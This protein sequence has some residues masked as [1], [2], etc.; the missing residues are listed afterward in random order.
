[1]YK[2][3]EEC[4]TIV[5][6]SYAK[7]DVGGQALITFKVDTAVTTQLSEKAKKYRQQ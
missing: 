7:V 2:R 3:E 1:M 5:D 6:S 4:T